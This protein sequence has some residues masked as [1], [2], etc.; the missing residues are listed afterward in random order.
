MLDKVLVSYKRTLSLFRVIKVKIKKLIMQYSYKQ[1]KR[2]THWQ[3][4]LWYFHTHN[5]SYDDKLQFSCLH[6][7]IR[8]MSIMYCASRARASRTRRRRLHA[9]D[10]T[11]DTRAWAK[12]LTA[13]RTASDYIT[14]LTRSS[15]F[16]ACNIEKQGK[17][18]GTRLHL[19]TYVQQCWVK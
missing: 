6:S 8:N 3:L 14:R 10:V 19:I 1:K 16:S 11:L 2:T 12:I 9:V 4:K 15:C 17:G 13:S 5:L 7:V 18:L